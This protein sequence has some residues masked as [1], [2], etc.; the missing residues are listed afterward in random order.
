MPT[1]LFRTMKVGDGDRPAVGRLP[2][3]LGVRIGIDVR[4]DAQDRVRPGKGMSVST[5]PYSL[6][7]HLLPKAYGGSADEPLWEI[8]D[9]RIGDPLAVRATR[10]AHHLQVEPQR[11]M[12]LNDYERALADTRDDWSRS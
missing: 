2:K 3:M 6:L 8:G 9:D 11:T 10:R 7:P 4:A 12:A 1:K 5:D